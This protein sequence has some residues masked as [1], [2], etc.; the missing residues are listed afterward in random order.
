MTAGPC[1]E[2]LRRS[3][4]DHPDRQTDG[5]PAISATLAV[6]PAD[7]PRA[8]PA[9][10]SRCPLTPAPATRRP[11]AAPTTPPGPPANADPGPSSSGHQCARGGGSGRP[12]QERCSRRI[13]V[14]RRRIAA[15][16]S[17]PGPLLALGPGARLE[18]R[19]PCRR[20]A[21]RKRARHDTGKGSSRSLRRVHRVRPGTGVNPGLRRP[22]AP[23][24][25]GAPRRPTRVVHPR[26]PCP[27]LGTS[28]LP[29][30]A[31]SSSG[32][33]NRTARLTVDRHRASRDRNSY[34]G[35]MARCQ[36]KTVCVHLARTRRR[37]PAQDG[38]LDQS[39]CVNT[40]SGTG[41]GGSAYR[42]TGLCPT[43]PLPGRAVG[44]VARG[45]TR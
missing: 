20:G 38:G 17:D 7:R 44:G 40:H 13:R 21:P 32:R 25:G 35:A 2:E 1:S 18:I 22:C 42:G 33:I 24:A 34:R 3:V 11:G 26:Q 6:I 27:P 14:S 43:G 45:S 19:S 39:S 41:R 12:S 9:P 5:G 4:A 28:P 15:P 31:P 16:W 30:P 36:P 10:A 37:C 23:A 29:D 8:P